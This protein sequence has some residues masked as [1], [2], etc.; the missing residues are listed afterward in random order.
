MPRPPAGLVGLKHQ[1]R[2]RPPPPGHLVSQPGAGLLVSTAVAVLPVLLM[3]PAEALALGGLPTCWPAGP[4]SGSAGLP[5]CAGV[6]S[7][8]VW[9]LRPHHCPPLTGPP[10]Q[11][12][13]PPAGG[14]DTATGSPPS[15]PAPSVHQLLQ[16]GQLS[17]GHS[18]VRLDGH[19]Q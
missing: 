7:W 1:R 5:A 11:I 2:Q 6:I 15:G 3:P 17:T 10:P 8:T 19:Q 4:W 9:Q 12:R 14:C 18:Q 13:L 16:V